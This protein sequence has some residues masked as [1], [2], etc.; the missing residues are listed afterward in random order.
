MQQPSLRRLLDYHLRI[1]EG[2]ILAP[3]LCGYHPERGERE[4]PALIQCAIDDGRAVRSF[5]VCDR[6]VNINSRDDVLMV[7]EMLRNA[8]T[9]QLVRTDRYGGFSRHT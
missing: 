3:R 1:L 4:L 6:Y 8:Q 7:E 2:H 9:R 5:D